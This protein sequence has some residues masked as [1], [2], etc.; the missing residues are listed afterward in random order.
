M[1][2]TINR[3]VR[4]TKLTPSGTNPMAAEANGRISVLNARFLT[5]PEAATT[6]VDPAMIDSEIASHGP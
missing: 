2:S 3:R 4:N 1:P 5:R 6:A